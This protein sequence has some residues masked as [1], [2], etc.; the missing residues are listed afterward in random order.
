[1]PPN[2][3]CPNC[4]MK[5]EDWHV[6]WYKTEARALYKGLAAMDCP[7]CGE[8]VGYQ[9]AMVGPAPSGV[10]LV[11]RYVYKAAEWAASQAVAAGGTLQGY[12]TTAGPGAQ[13]ATYWTPQEVVRADAN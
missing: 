3:D 8:P 4:G 2:Q 11:R 10:A 6:E 1:M 7:L 13:Y 5:I 12:T 9:Q